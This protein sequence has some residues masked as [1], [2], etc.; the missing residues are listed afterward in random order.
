MY[1]FLIN[2]SEKFY[3]LAS[4][5]NDIQDAIQHFKISVDI[6]DDFNISLDM[7]DVYY[8]SNFDYT[9]TNDDL[10]SWP[11]WENNYLTNLSDEELDKELSSFRGQWWKD[12][13]KQWL[14]DKFPYIVVINAGNFYEI[15]DGRGRV[16]VA[17]GLG[18]KTLPAIILT[19]KKNHPKYKELINM[20]NSVYT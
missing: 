6:P 5:Q 2:I 1:D 20:I 12:L 8:D 17:L 19:L 4:L 10:S 18:I 16:S 15:S 9:K 7:F 3:K 14:S 13:A 11:E